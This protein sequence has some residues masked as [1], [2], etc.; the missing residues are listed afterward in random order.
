VAEV[1][2]QAG[3]VRLVLVETP[4]VLGGAESVDEERDPASR[5][6]ERRRELLPLRRQRAV[7]D[8]QLRADPERPPL[9]LELVADHA[10]E[11]PERMLGPRRNGRRRVRRVRVEGTE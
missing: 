5:V 11:G 9:P 3:T 6:G 1:V 8:P 4:G 7:A 2:A 10:A